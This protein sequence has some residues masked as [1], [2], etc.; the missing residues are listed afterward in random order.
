VTVHL[1]HWFAWSV[2]QAESLLQVGDDGE[3]RRDAGYVQGKADRVD[4]GVGDE[5]EAPTAL[6]RCPVRMSISP[7]TVTTTA[8]ATRS[9]LMEA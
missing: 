7:S 1:K 5:N 6:L 3:Q 9:V 2:V 8:S 4:A